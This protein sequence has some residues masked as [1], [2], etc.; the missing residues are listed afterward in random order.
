MDIFH[1]F[2]RCVLSDALFVFDFSGQVGL[3]V[4][5][6]RP[7]QSDNLNIKII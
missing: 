1:F 3:N 6:W 2:W 5:V 7:L 4:S